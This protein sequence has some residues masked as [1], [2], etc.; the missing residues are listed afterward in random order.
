MLENMIDFE[1]IKENVII[2]K[3]NDRFK[4]LFSSLYFENINLLKFYKSI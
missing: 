4:E 3:M 2:L 1:F